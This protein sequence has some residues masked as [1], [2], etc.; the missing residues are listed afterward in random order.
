MN[1]KFYEIE[2]IKK[3]QTEII[4]KLENTLEG[5]NSKLDEVEVKISE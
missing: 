3:D 5:F 2:N 1:K 4:T